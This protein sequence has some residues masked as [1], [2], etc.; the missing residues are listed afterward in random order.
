MN[1]K[2]I[3]EACCIGLL[4]VF[5]DPADTVFPLQVRYFHRTLRDFLELPEVHDWMGKERREGDLRS[6]ALVALQW[7]LESLPTLDSVC[8]PARARWLTYTLL[9]Q[10]SRLEAKGTPIESRILDNFDQAATSLAR[11]HGVLPWTWA[12]FIE[13]ADG[14]DLPGCK[15]FL[16]LVIESQFVSYVRDRLDSKVVRAKNGRPFFDYALLPTGRFKPEAAT[17]SRLVQYI[18]AAGGDPNEK[19]R[20]RTV[21]ERFLQAISR[22]TRNGSSGYP[23][24]EEWTPTVMSLVRHGAD[25]MATIV[26]YDDGRGRTLGVDK[27]VG[28]SVDEV[29]R[30]SS[31]QDLK[32]KGISLSRFA[33][34]FRVKP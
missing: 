4:E 17:T 32:G 13:D 12:D 24:K 21:W 9:N 18:L 22:E 10:A 11:K 29:E 7:V 19:W 23:T 3:I 33:W 6:K 26:V 34:C 8:W 14:L 5:E 30:S 16:A 31:T 20:D 25:K 28:F 1:A 27:I 2:H 15:M